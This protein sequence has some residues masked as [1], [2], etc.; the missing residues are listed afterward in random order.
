MPTK[1]IAIPP[2]V[3]PTPRE[4]RL[5]RSLWIGI[6]AA[7]LAPLIWECAA[8]CHSQWCEV[9]GY[10]REAQTPILDALHGQLES[11]QQTI[12]ESIESQFGDFQWDAKIAL[13]V[14]GIL[15]VLAMAMLKR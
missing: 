12:R 4:S 5:P 14:G 1:S 7:V 8:I 11:A 3:P 15:V 9:I 13:S 2:A 10:P 6:L